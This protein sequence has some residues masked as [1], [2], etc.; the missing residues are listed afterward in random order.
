MI[1]NTDYKTQKDIL[2]SLSCLE[3]CMSTV[4][5]C[6]RL[7]RDHRGR[8]HT[9]IGTNQATVWEIATV[10]RLRTGKE[11]LNPKRTDYKTTTSP[12]GSIIVE[13]RFADNPKK[14]F[15]TAAELD[16]EYSKI[17][18][19]VIPM[20]NTNYANNATS[21]VGIQT[22]ASDSKIVRV[23]SDVSKI[24]AT[25][26]GI[27]AVLAGMKANIK[28]ANDSVRELGASLS[29]FG[30]KLRKQLGKVKAEYNRRAKTSK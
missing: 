22:N 8:R 4:K 28:P 15:A 26:A 20:A 13:E 18:P 12:D 25:I 11:P 14:W 2:K 5:S 21:N 29:A 17:S 7:L 16:R 1:I 3:R 19:S 27:T 30:N 24:V 9:K 6:D 23:I 10:I